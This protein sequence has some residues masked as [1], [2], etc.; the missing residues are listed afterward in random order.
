MKASKG[1]KKQNEEE[2]ESSSAGGY[3]ICDNEPFYDGYV[4]SEK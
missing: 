2:E 4:S 1:A 3:H